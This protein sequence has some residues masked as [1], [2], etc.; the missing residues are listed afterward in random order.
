MKKLIG[1][2]LRLLIVASVVGVTYWIYTSYDDILE[3]AQQEADWTGNRLSDWE[4]L[5]Q[6][7]VFQKNAELQ[8][9][10]ELE[11]AEL[12]E[13]FE[14]NR[15]LT[16]EEFANWQQELQWQIEWNEEFSDDLVAG[17][18]FEGLVDYYNELSP[19]EQVSMTWRYIEFGYRNGFFHRWDGWWWGDN[20]RNIHT[21]AINH[22]TGATF[23]EHH[24]LLREVYEQVENSQL[25]DMYQDVLMVHFDEE[26]NRETGLSLDF[27]TE[28]WELL[29]WRR[30]RNTTFVFGIPYELVSG[31][32]IFWQQIW[33]LQSA[34]HDEVLERILPLAIGIAVLALLIPVGF[35]KKSI[36]MRIPLEIAAMIA[37]LAVL[38][39]AESGQLLNAYFQ[40]QPTFTFEPLATYDN[41]LITLNIGLWMYLF[42]AIA[43]LILYI[44][45]LF[46]QGFVQ[47]LIKNTL[48]VGVPYGITQLFTVKN[49]GYL[50][51]LES[52]DQMLVGE[53]DL[54]KDFGP[55]EAMKEKLQQIQQKHQQEIADIK[56]SE[57]A[58][59]ALL[60]QNI[61]ELEGPLSNAL[62]QVAYLQNV[63]LE[64]ETRSEI[65]AD[66]TGHL[67]QMQALMD[68]LQDSGKILMR[69]VE[70]IT[71]LEEALFSVE[72][73]LMKQNLM[74]RTNFPPKPVMAKADPR[75]LGAIFKGLMEHLASESIPHTRAYIDVDGTVIT[76]RH[77]S[78]TGLS[79]EKFQML[80]ELQG[81]TLTWSRDGDLNKMTLKVKE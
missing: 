19:E 37:F 67:E 40:E 1:W 23:G 14:L 4:W 50:H 79:L 43:F 75:H 27:F 53:L 16:A 45:H 11:D 64:Q 30:P 77:M 69:D 55:Y 39:V 52:A 12:E 76:F 46:R 44:K 13:V 61:S 33:Q 24:Q 2:L 68:D 78:E 51:L 59:T 32:Q 25:R 72:G 18:N 47:T 29:N 66:L 21:F 42:G 63:E 57:H 26:G 70:L 73:E 28:E 71:L 35:L 6:Q 74:M 38:F 5:V 3:E 8:G 41:L 22:D 36:F 56:A 58:K 60:H 80:V 31:D 9:I 62:E 81:G 49:K 17:R 15:L 54:D 48:I 65:V 10:T 34:I 7:E 20:I